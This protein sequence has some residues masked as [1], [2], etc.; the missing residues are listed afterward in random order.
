M[1]VLWLASFRPINKLGE[2]RNQ[3]MFADTVKSLDLSKCFIK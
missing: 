3:S 1:R 2:N